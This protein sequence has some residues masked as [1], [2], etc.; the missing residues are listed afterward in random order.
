LVTPR[1]PRPNAARAAQPPGTPT[2]PASGAGSQAREESCPLPRA[3]EQTRCAASSNQTFQSIHNSRRLLTVQPRKSLQGRGPRFASTHPRVPAACA[4]PRGTGSRP[5]RGVRTGAAALPSAAYAEH[6][7]RRPADEKSLLAL[8]ISK[9][10]RRSART[11][12]TCT[13]H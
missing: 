10:T 9:V 3:S 2:A 8:Q 12:R 7:R 11:Q 1:A 4:A 6:G 13:L 5:T